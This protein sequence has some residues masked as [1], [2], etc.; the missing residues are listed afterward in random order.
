MSSLVE[1]Q[2]VEDTADV[3]DQE[4]EDTAETVADTRVE[5]LVLEDLEVTAEDH[6]QVVLEVDTAEALVLED[7]EDTHLLV[8]MTTEVAD[9]RVEVLVLE[10]LEV[11]AEDHRQMV[12]EADTRVDRV[13]VLDTVVLRVEATEVTHSATMVHLAHLA[14]STQI[15]HVH[16]MMHNRYKK[17][18]ERSSFLC[19]LDQPFCTQYP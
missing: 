7:Q 13:E 5:A 18:S 4:V 6:R 15:V 17:N 9:T 16:L 11:T 12:L 1:D 19:L 2:E 10:D 8:V 14:V 3:E